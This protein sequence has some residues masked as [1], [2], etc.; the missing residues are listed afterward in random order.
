MRRLQGGNS[1]LVFDVVLAYCHALLLRVCT[2]VQYIPIP[3]A[4]TLNL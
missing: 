3:G 2:Y 4:L 1:S